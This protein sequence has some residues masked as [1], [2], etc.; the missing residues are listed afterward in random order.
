M[1]SRDENLLGG[2]TASSF[3]DKDLLVMV[4]D[5]FENTQCVPPFQEPCC[6]NPT[7]FHY[8]KYFQPQLRAEAPE[9]RWN[10]GVQGNRSWKGGGGKL[11]W[12]G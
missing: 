5:S 10:C 3:S 1:G 12:K 4:T 6:S 8:P 7:C 9:S 11:G 2:L